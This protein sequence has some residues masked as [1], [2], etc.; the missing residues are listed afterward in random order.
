MLGGAEG[1]GRVH[2]APPCQCLT[3]TSRR[4]WL[5]D[6]ELSGRAYPRCWAD[7]AVAGTAEE[8]PHR[9]APTSSSAAFF[10]GGLD[11]LGSFRQSQPFV[12]GLGWRGGLGRLLPIRR[13]SWPLMTC[14]LASN[15]LGR[16]AVV[17]APRAV[18]IVVIAPVVHALTAAHEL[19]RIDPA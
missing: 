13:A 7:N 15:S 17:A 19:Q 4:T 16:A 3:H 14:S 12:A 8:A 2:G 10:L 6:W 9:A 5:C 18:H 1:G 11:G